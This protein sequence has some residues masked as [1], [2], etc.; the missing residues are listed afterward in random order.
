MFGLEGGAVPAAFVLTVLS[1]ALCVVYGAVNW[2]RGGVT[3]EE[4]ARQEIWDGE[5]KQIEDKL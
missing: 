2:N 1:A 3:E 4:L 5:E